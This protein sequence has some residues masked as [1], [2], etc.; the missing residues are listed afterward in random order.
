MLAWRESAP[1]RLICV[2]LAR[3]SG[4]SPI[5]SFLPAMQLTLV[6]SVGKEGRFLRWWNGFGIE[7]GYR[8]W[9]ARAEEL[10]Q[11]AVHRVAI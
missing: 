3:D 4:Y 2:A 11:Q 8:W 1:A 7:K 9:Q 10:G 6:E 5:K